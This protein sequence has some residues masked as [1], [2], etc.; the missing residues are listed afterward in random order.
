MMLTTH[1]R[2]ELYG[3]AGYIELIDSW[4][5]DERI[6]EAARM[7]TQRGFDGW[8][9]K[10]DRCGES[11]GGLAPGFTGDPLE[12]PVSGCGGRKVVPGDEKLLR[13]LWKNKHA[14]P[15]EMAGAT[16]EV[17]APIFVFREWHR[18]RVP[19]G[20]NE[21]SARYAPLPAIDY[22]PTVERIMAGGGHLTKQA[23]GADGSTALSEGAALDFTRALDVH[24]ANAEALYQTALRTGIPKELARLALTVGRCS[25]MRATG[26]LRGWIGFMAL[27]RTMNAQ[28]EIREPANA[29]HK[30]LTGVFP[31]TLEIV[32]STDG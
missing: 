18:H 22:T 26:N 14:T 10:C 8:G 23:A 3:G 4:G 24:Y 12:C 15:F 25:K 1:E 20:Y 27:R 32:G 16:F 21:A 5:S 13:Y 31:R 30:I 28:Q 11:G 19:F 9:P 29:I 2:I 6:V 7:S 17:Q